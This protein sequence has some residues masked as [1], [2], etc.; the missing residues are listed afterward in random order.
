MRQMCIQRARTCQNGKHRIA[1]SVSERSRRS[2]PIVA[3]MRTAR[4]ASCALARFHVEGQLW[5]SR[6]ASL[7]LPSARTH[8][9]RRARARVS[10][11]ETTPPSKQAR[12][13]GRASRQGGGRFGRQLLAPR[14]GPNQLLH[15]RQSWNC[16]SVPPFVTSDELRH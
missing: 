3:P 4:Q 12:P 13:L 14:S 6:R 9:G 1:S 8:G 7:A 15:P 11:A 2:R 10:R 5:R 16:V